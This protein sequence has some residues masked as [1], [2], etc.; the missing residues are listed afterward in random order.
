MSDDMRKASFFY[1]YEIQGTF[2]RNE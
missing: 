1:I 2:Q